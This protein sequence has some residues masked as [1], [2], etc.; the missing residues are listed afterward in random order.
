MTSRRLFAGLGLGAS[1]L[2]LAAFAQD[3]PPPRL[4]L[5]LGASLTHATNPDLVTSG[6]KSDTTAALTFGLQ[7]A[8]TTRDTALRYGLSGQLQSGGGIGDPTLTFSYQRQGQGSSFRFD[9]Q[10]SDQAVDLSEPL[11]LAN[12]QISTA[13]LVATTGRVQASTATLG[14]ETG[15]DA[16]LGFEFAATLAARDYSQTSDPSV[17]DSQSDSLQA[18]AHLRDVAGGNLDLTAASS[19]TRAEDI[20]R[21]RQQSQSLGLSYS[22]QLASGLTL[23]GSLGTTTAETRR[24]GIVTASSSGLTAGLGATQALADGSAALG[25][26]LDRDARGA[27]Q[28]LTL[29]RELALKTTKLSAQIG[30]TTR[31]GGPGTATGSLTL[32]TELPADS[33]ALQLS[34]QMVLNSDDQDTAETTASA[35][36]SHKVGPTSSLSLGYSLS[37]VTGLGGAAVDGVTRQSLTASWSQD[38]ARDW[39]LRAGVT[40]RALD[41]DSTGSA[42]DDA[43]FLTISRKFGLQP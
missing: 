3:A 1:A 39:A 9:L 35:D 38:L 37:A 41:R 12:G 11:T 2:A 26:T 25:L 28:S 15:K 4:V 42:R 8:A 10:A 32:A 6:A 27:R 43:V 7:G 29:G 21:S 22:Q 14:F 36:W 30:Y 13:A 16:R 34:R 24:L 18:T 40:L 31:D 19:Q 20:F 5:D 33:L 17:Y 23:T